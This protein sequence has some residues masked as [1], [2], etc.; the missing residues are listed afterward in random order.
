M[1]PP[2]LPRDRKPLPAAR[3]VVAFQRRERDAERSPRGALQ[4]NNYNLR[5]VR[6]EERQQSILKRRLSLARF[7]RRFLSPCSECDFFPLKF[8]S[9]R[10]ALRAAKLADTFV[11]AI[12]EEISPIPSRDLCRSRQIL[13][14]I[15]FRFTRV[16]AYRDVL[17]RYFGRKR[18]AHL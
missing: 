11:G 2:L 10:G 12:R 6:T 7:S 9:S 1:S 17:A 13:N 15:N 3:P 16:P 8:K 5:R 14:L 4:G 18:R